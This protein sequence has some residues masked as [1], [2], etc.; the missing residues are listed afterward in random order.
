MWWGYQ[1]KNIF[2]KSELKKSINRIEISGPNLIE[3][4]PL[5]NFQTKILIWQKKD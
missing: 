1:E 2:K 4:L 3:T 5:L